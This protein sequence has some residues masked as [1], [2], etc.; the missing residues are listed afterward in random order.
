M[1][2]ISF[3]GRVTFSA[4]FIL[5]AWQKIQDFGDDGGSALKTLEPKL[6]LFKGHIFETLH[7]KVPPVETKH[8]LMGAIALEGFGGLLFTVGSSVGAYLLLIFL[9]AITP[10]IHDFYNYELSSPEIWHFS[11]P[12]C[13]SWV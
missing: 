7:F 3:V 5:A 6:D 9:A 13:S 12:F 4:I 11:E 2:F 1:G 10:I 8:L